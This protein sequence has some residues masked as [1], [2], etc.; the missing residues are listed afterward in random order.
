MGSRWLGCVLLFS[1]FF[2]DDIMIFSRAN[3][4]EAQAIINCIT[5]YSSW[6]GHRINIAKSAVFFS[7]NCRL[8]SKNVV[9]AIL[10]FAPIPARSK[11][12]GIPLFFNRRK[13]DSFIELK[14]IIFAKVTGWKA[15][16]LSQAA[17]TTLI[18]SVANAIPTYIM[19]LFLLPKSLCANIKSVLRKFWWG[20]PQDKKHNLSLLS[21]GNIC[22]PKALGGLGIRSMEFLN[23]SLL[24]RLGWKMV[25][26]QPLLWVDALRGKYL[27]NGI[28]FLFATPKPLSSWLW[29]GLLKIGIL[30]P[31]VLAFLFLVV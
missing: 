14:D 31:K 27:K 17:R 8:T 18:K 11:Y 7:K 15:K 5:T 19:S 9:N 2:A 20:F 10:N 23:S 22:Q 13:K 4:R 12:L 30:L 16:L 21:R 28:S 29:N 3:V 24:A 1:S 6:S 25:S 26:N